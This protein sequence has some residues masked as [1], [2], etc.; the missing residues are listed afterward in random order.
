MIK[1]N[2]HMT[3]LAP[4]S[5]N[6]VGF[7]AEF[8]VN[9]RLLPND[10]VTALQEDVKAG[11]KSGLEFAREV[12]DG[13]PDGA[14]GDAGGNPLPPAP[15]NVAGLLRMPGVPSAVINA[16]WRGYDEATEGN[17]EPLPAGS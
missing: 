1:L 4:I 12:L 16:F 5:I 11:R 15:D 14:V 10:V 17:S 2:P 6:L 3:F 8:S 7:Q 13:W 9:L